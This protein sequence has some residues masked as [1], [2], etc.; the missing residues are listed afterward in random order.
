MEMVE[1]E[2]ESDLVSEVFAAILT[3]E[4]TRKMG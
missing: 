4:F 2:V 3:S 1:I